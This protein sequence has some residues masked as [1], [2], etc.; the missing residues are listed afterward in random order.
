MFK[1]DILEP[2]AFISHQLPPPPSVDRH[3]PAN[4]VNF[5]GKSYIKKNYFYFPFFFSKLNLAT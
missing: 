2:A 3:Q 5:F 4:S 1:P